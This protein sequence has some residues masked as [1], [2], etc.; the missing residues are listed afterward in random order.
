MDISAIGNLTA[1]LGAPAETSTPPPA[2]TEQRSLIQA[3]RAVNAADLFGQDKELTFVLDRQTHKAVVRIVNRDT[4]EVIQQ[5][6]AEYVLRMAE[7]Y[8]GR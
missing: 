4:R 2:H 7:E 6:P 1:Q 5:I 8:S 3:V